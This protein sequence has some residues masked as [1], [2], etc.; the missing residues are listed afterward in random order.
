V[1]YLPV[2]LR[3]FPSASYFT[4]VSGNY[5]YSL[6]EVNLLANYTTDLRTFQVD[7]TGSFGG[8]STA[9]IFA[10]SN[11]ANSANVYIE[12]SAEL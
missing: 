7:L 12:Y 5:D 3:A 2:P 8:T 4:P 10:S 6:T 9:A 11:S 1:I